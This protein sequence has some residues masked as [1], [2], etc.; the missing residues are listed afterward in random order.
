M[1]PLLRVSLLALALAAGCGQKGPLVLKPARPKTPVTA[2]ATPA[3][4]AVQATPT[5]PAASAQPAADEKKDPAG[6]Q[7]AAPRS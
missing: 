5:S 1:R 4:P 6:D 3:T 7:P 2:P